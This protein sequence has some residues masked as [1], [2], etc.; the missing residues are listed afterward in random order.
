[1]NYPTLAAQIKALRWV[2]DGIDGSAETIAVRELLY[3]AQFSRQALSNVLAF[4][5]VQ[6][7][8][9]AREAD[10]ID[11]VVGFNDAA[12]S[13]AIT[14]L[15]WVQ[16][17]INEVERQAIQGLAKISA[18]DTNAAAGV[19]AL[20]WV[21][22]GIN[23]RDVSAIAEAATPTPTS[24]PVP[25]VSLMLD[26]EPEI[27]GYWSNGTAGLN[28]ALTL[29]NVGTLEYTGSQRVSVHCPIGDDGCRW[30]VGIPVPREILISLPDGFG[31]V[32]AEMALK[33]PMGATTLQLE[34]GGNAPVALKVD[35]PE[36]I[37]GVE[38]EVWECY[39]DRQ[40]VPV[41]GFDQW[42]YGC[43]GWS[44]PV[45]KWR[46]DVP[47]KYWTTGHED[48]TVL[49]EEA[50]E[51]LAPLLN[52]EFRRVERQYD[53]DLWVFVGIPREEADNY[54]LGVSD[55]YVTD[56]GGFASVSQQAGEATSGRLVVWLRDDYDDANVH[57]RH[58]AYGTIVHELLHAMTTNGHTT[59]K[60]NAIA[61]RLSPME[62][63]LI[64]LNSHR[65]VQPGMTMEEVREV[66]VLR[67]ELLDAPPA[68]ELDALGMLWRATVSLA[69]A[70]DIRFK[71]RGGQRTGGC[72]DTFGVRR[73]WATLE[74]GAQNR[75]GRFPF[76][77]HF[78]DYNVGIISIYTNATGEWGWNHWLEKAAGTWESIEWKE[79][80]WASHWW[81]YGNK[82]HDT[83]WSLIRDDFHP[84][85]I[86]IAARSN[87]TVTLRA[88][89]DA[90]YSTLFGEWG[91]REAVE[92]QLVLDDS[93]YKVRGY[94]WRELT[95]SRAGCT[96]YEEEAAEFEFG[97]N[98]AIPKSVLRDLGC[99]TVEQ[100]TDGM[101]CR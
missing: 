9:D 21:Q 2:Q 86:T 43:G 29:R 46:S 85:S 5:W 19:M 49:L 34:Y 15:S 80:H 13:L 76:I 42:T 23:T 82:L 4:E 17:G 41:P 67:D 88:T 6:D 98:L 32:S 40:E 24:T 96:T 91:D 92:F 14:K 12:N 89:L 33:V 51:K 95:P 59:R 70:G 45:S 54:D 39:A 69:N 64:R 38:R 27:A 26:A 93:T 16:D 56:T 52:L 8:V 1:M 18:T 68:Q 81:L 47:V 22:D 58:G 63:A 83:M 71:I 99:D 65:L 35:V 101:P 90:T 97:I 66:V 74:L 3:V 72:N 50:I 78:D 79:A 30:P 25:R 77:V 11:W 48:Y 84:G 44:G 57:H 61:G 53:A 37:L 10:A 94:T 87:G 28:V 20:P 75:S 36:R 62:E 60:V 31:P 100:V 55:W 7:G 73:G